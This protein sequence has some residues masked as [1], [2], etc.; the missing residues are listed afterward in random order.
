MPWIKVRDKVGEGICKFES[1]DPEHEI[2]FDEWALWKDEFGNV[3]KA[4][5]KLDAYDHFYPSP[6]LLKEEN[7]EAFWLEEGKDNA[8]DQ[9]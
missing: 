1:L 9:D 7:L 4:R 2:P 3:E 8:T 6:K 5:L